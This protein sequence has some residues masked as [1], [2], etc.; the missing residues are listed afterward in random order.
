MENIVDEELS[1]TELIE[2]EI[3][4]KMQNAFSKMARMAALI[5]NEDGVA[6]TEGTNFSD[7]CTEYCRKSA[8][9]KARCEN[10]DKMGAV[11]TLEQKKP[12]SYRCHASLVDFAAP[13]MLGD[14]MIGSFIGGQVLAEE[15]SEEVIRKVAREIEVNEDDL[16][17]AAKKVQIIPQGAITRSTEFIYEFAQII[18]DMAYNAHISRELSKQAMQAAVQKS[19]FLANM[20]HE[21]RTPMNAVLGMAEMA[22]RED[23]SHEAKEYIRQIQSSGK[24]LLVIINDIL[25]FS[26]IDSGKMQI[27][28]TIFEFGVLLEDIIQLVNSRIGDKDIEFIVDIVKDVPRE[29]YGD[30]VRIEQILINLLNNAIKFTAKGKITLKISYEP[31]D[32]ENIL[33]KFGV[34]D[35]GQG[36]KKEDIGKLFASFQQI[37]S[38]RNRNIEGTGLGLAITKQL[39]ELMKGQITVES[40]YGVGTTFSLEFPIRVQTATTPI[41]EFDKNKQIYSLIENAYV[42]EM[43]VKDLE[44]IDINLV[45][46]TE[47]DLPEFAEGD[48]IITERKIY[49]DQLSKSDFSKLNIIV[50]EEFDTPNDIKAKNV[51]VVKKPVYS[52]KLY[53]AMGLCEKFE[54]DE[55]S[56]DNIFSFIAPEAKVLVVDDNQINLTVA[57]G[58]LE[59]LKMHV[60]TAGGALEC[61]EKAKEI[62]YDVIFMDH[63]MPEVD[64]IETTHILRRMIEGY[65]AV[66]IIALTANAVGGAKEMF[67]KEGMNDFVAKPIETKKIVAKLK[68]WL[69]VEKIVPIEAE[70]FRMDDDN[71]DVTELSK[72]TGLDVHEGI[73]MLG[74]YK[75]YMDFIEAYYKDIEKKIDILNNDVSKK[76]YDNYTIVIHSIKSASRQIGANE[77]AE[78]AAR[79]EKAGNDKN[80]DIIDAENANFV[81]DY[82]CLKDKI[83]LAI[84][85]LAVGK[86]KQKS[87]STITLDCLDEL[88]EA[89][90]EFDILA[91]DEAFD[92]INGLEFDSSEEKV[93]LDKL[94]AVH[95]D[96][97]LDTC[98]IIVDKWKKLLI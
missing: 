22:L 33:L 47:G 26:K 86:N 40:E 56:D 12:V 8:I 11:M 95:D 58:L 77:L 24:H 90:N 13:I 37:D 59:P 64:G 84:P 68:Q 63:M 57:K 89:L 91:I 67:I 21:I 41:K 36:I 55:D 46:L 74:S 17:E 54:H 30:T 76:D 34:S 42:K 62:H 94:N 66:P 75:L 79:L 48:Y 2:V 1:L 15:P 88:L 43:L 51:T 72:L 81:K 23:M 31:I 65:D 20:S 70:G 87:E 93:L 82:E 19:D 52:R 39:L 4:Q 60:D 38:K 96:Y 73:R 25:D 29:L 78:F 27:V 16:W 32:S 44:K 61:I 28:E 53:V 10:C 71:G 92:K 50:I 98:S 14:R 6:V 85:N 45:N 97:D 35:T 18:S 3:L 9:G 7:F 69:P 5:T 49:V 80:T 83:L